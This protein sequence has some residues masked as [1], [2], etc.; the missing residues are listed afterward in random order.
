M[1][2]DADSKRESIQRFRSQQLQTRKNEE[3][4]AL[5]HEIERFEKDIVAI[6]DKELEVM[7]KA[8]NLHVQIG[9]AE[10]QLAE[11]KRRSESV[12][13]DLDRKSAA[14]EEQLAKYASEKQELEA[15]V[16]ED[17]LS[18]YG[19]LFASKGDSAVVPI[20]HGVCMGCH[21]KITTQT[22]VR[23]KAGT[24]ILSCDQCGRILYCP[25]D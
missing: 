24:E 8:E 25:E 9:E 17:L 2:I 12:L 20:E 22:V 15:G 21:M 4:Q 3:Y 18:R 6:E 1:E 23:V 10:K 14:I 11:E 16:E 13:A 5:T 7:E 19:R